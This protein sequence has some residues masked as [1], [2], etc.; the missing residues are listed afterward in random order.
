M[1]KIIETRLIM[2]N[3][4][5]IDIVDIEEGNTIQKLLKEKIIYLNMQMPCKTHFGR[6][7]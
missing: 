6:F 4:V 7:T 1:N 5:V 3:T 2:I